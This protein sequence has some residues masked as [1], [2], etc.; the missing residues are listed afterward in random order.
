M[1]ATS[2]PRT[3][4]FALLLILAL[5]LT[6]IL[7]PQAAQAAPVAG[8]AESPV[9]ELAEAPTAQSAM[10]ITLDAIDDA[11][12]QAG[13]PDAN[14][15]SG[16]L[17]VGQPNTH[18]SFVQ[19]DLSMIPA[20]AVVTGAGLEL[21]FTGA[22]TGTND[23]EVGAAG[24]AWD[25]LTLTYATQP[26][27][28]WG[29]PVQTVTS[30][31]LNDSSVVTWN[32]TQLVQAWHNGA[33]PNYGF[34]LRGN[35]GTLKAFYSKENGT[36]DLLPQLVIALEKAADDD[37]PRP[38][39]GDAPDS[40]NHHGQ[41]NTAYPGAGVL[42]QFPTVWEVP[43]GQPAGPRHL[44]QTMEGFL[45][46][47]ISRE[48]EADQGPDQDAPRNNILRNINTG[49]I[50]D[51]ADNDRA[52]DGWRN[53]N[54]KF[55]DCREATLDMRISKGQNATRKFMYLNVWFDGNRSGDWGQLG[56]CAATA[57]EPAQASYEWIVQNYIVDMTAIPTG[58]HLD[59]AI[60][61]EMVMNSTPGLPHWMRFT[62]SEEP[63]T[64]P[65]TGGLP[66]GRGPHPNSLLKS[67]QFGETEDVFQTPPPPGEDG[68]LVVE[69]RVVTP[70]SPVNWPETVTY[71]ISLRHEG[72]TQPMQAELRDLLPY[73]QH[74]LPRFIDGDAVYFN[75][76]TPTGGAN[77]LSANLF[78]NTTESLPRQVVYW[79]GTLNPNSEVRLSF[80]VH[81]HPLCRAGQQTVTLTNLV[82]ARPYNG[83]AISDEAS[84]EA[85]CPGY[86]PPDIQIDPEPLEYP[87]DLDDLT[88]VQWRG[89]L[90]NNHKIPVT[91]GAVFEPN[92][93][94]VTSAG[95]QAGTTIAKLPIL[96]RF[97]LEPGETR[98]VNI[99]LRMENVFTD[100]FKLADDFTPGGQ[101]TF[102]FLT[103]ESTQCP[104]AAE[105][106]NLVV[107]APPFDIEYRP[108]DLGDAPD[109][110]NH[111]GAAMSA[112]AGV[113][114]DFPTVF[115]VATGLPP[116]PLHRHPRPFHLGRRVSQEAEADV[117]P[118]Q[119]PVNNILPAANNPNNDRGDDGT[120]FAL[121]NLNDCQTTNLPVQIFISPQAV[122]YFQNL[123]TPA[124]V[125]IWLDSNRNGSWADAAQCGQQAAPEHI[126]IDAPVDVVGLG[127]GLHNIVVPTGLV[128]WPN[129]DRPAWVRISLSEIP[130]NKT[131]QAGDVKYGDGRGYPTGFKTG[132]TEDYLYRP[133]LAGGGPD[134]DVQLSAQTRQITAQE[135]GQLQAASADK[136]GNFEIQLFKIEYG[137][138][139]TA[140][141]KG[142][143]LSFQIPEALR[144]TKP[145][146]FRSPQLSPSSFKFGNNEILWDLGTM[147]PNQFG[148]ITLG[149]TG[150]LTCTVAAANVNADSTGNVNV[151]LAD[152]VDASNN[153]SSATARGLLSSPILGMPTPNGAL[154][155]NEVIEGIAVTNRTQIDLVGKAAPNQSIV[156]RNGNAELA[157]VKSDG[158]GT[159]SHTVSL[160]E[161]RYTLTA[162][163]VKSPRDAASG[164]AT[165]LLRL[166][167]QP[168]LPFDPSSLCFVDS[169][170]DAF[171]FAQL[172][173]KDLDKSSPLALQRG[174]T[175]QV[176]VS[177]LGAKPN[178]ALKI[179]LTDVIISSLTDAD[180]DGI[181]TGSFTMDAA[182]LAANVNA[183][184]SLGLLVD[185]GSSVVTFEIPTQTVG[186]GMVTDNAGKPLANATVTLLDA[187]EV[188][189]SE[190]VYTTFSA[191]A[192]QVTGNDGSFSFLP[193]S[194][195]SRID[196]VAPGY[197]AYR[198]ANI[199]GDDNVN[200]SVVLTPEIAE[201]A[202][203]TVYLTENG[204]EPAT[205]LVE[206]G[207][208]IEF[209]NI[210][211]ADHGTTSSTWDSGLL[212]SGGNYKVKL[213]NE[214]LFTHVDSA[215]AGNQGQITVNGDPVALG[216]VKVYLPL[217]T[218]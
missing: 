29:G 93:V 63:A 57:D 188:E 133:A 149:W 115:D 201:A 206:P 173:S 119:D 16:F 166:V 128:R 148:T 58:G 116:G 199:D 165:G 39:L 45:G 88:Q 123:N 91:L 89:E 13:S 42:G 216:S 14:F 190:A 103:D 209:V 200:R 191:V 78:Y 77:P 167:V 24:G 137:N 100:E 174:E 107:N 154:C 52:D 92:D 68:K 37:K 121:W 69:K 141:A 23:V 28:T 140:A 75:V 153:Q 218:R 84:F 134:L 17:W 54:V 182:L 196:V 82:T 132:E 208:V 59:F 66:D 27:I 74:L 179:T 38:D 95:A 180:R 110:T 80:D 46:N 34:A 19:F 85:A 33:T 50:A 175:Y 81:V 40:T 125:N 49:A 65:P 97:T 72:G 204:F 157:T 211:F 71:Q 55:F 202:T 32:V 162:N 111:A 136:L 131:L 117:G 114:A 21:S 62:L 56:Q 18:F 152:D 26:N 155:N 43:N 83:N 156:I 47:F 31:G 213:N 118:D 126:V 161:G 172:V 194:G 7:S 129:S 101:L 143:V 67:Y 120:N 164:M 70:G 139:G 90:R 96:D 60:N 124:Y 212:T 217:V 61:T 9:A 8:L 150:C 168:T 197:Q 25:E 98:F 104:D 15:G 20:D 189:D 159:F 158:N 87:I 169:Q 163:Y 198:S 187:T 36:P 183:D 142:G 127:A 4:R 41:P 193:T 151:T 6:S 192:A 203:H 12:T 130:S 94:N 214:G 185:D 146:L 144:G 108:S 76:T 177:G 207:S 122:N 210:D 44:N 3:Q 79:R 181:Y 73:P 109:S 112:Y 53:R 99:D 170:G 105:Y 106:P 176:S 11:R 113:Q 51:V 171:P 135:A 160:A 147:E 1:N 184:R 48:G 138:V 2:I 186:S 145:T 102:C 64:Q 35:S 30:T 195:I 86:N 5:L 22:Y 10:T 205:L 178:H 215:G